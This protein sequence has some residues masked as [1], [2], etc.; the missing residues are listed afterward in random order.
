MSEQVIH[1]RDCEFGRE[2]EPF[3]VFSH[4]A[5]ANFT[6][7][8]IVTGIAGTQSDDRFNV[9]PLVGQHPAIAIDQSEGTEIALKA[10]VLQ[11]GEYA[12]GQFDTA[13]VVVGVEH[14][15]THKVTSKGGAKPIAGFGLEGDV[16]NFLVVVKSN[17]SLDV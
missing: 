11:F 17:Y 1:D 10:V 9:P 3:V 14:V 8:F 6:G 5:T 4:F 16:F 12:K 7:I 13:C 2:E 15:G